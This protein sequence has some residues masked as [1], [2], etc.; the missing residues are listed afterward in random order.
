MKNIGLKVI[1]ALL[2][3]TMQAQTSNC[4]NLSEQLQIFHSNLDYANA[5]KSWL[6]IKKNCPT[7]SE[8]NYL[9]AKEILQYKLD[10]APQ[11][12]IQK[13]LNEFV[14]FYDLYD[15]SFPD[16]KSNNALK[17]AILIV[18][19]TGANE[20]NLQLLERAI[21]KS[22]TAIFDTY[23]TYLFT[24]SYYDK[25]T[26]KEI[27][28]ETFF[29]KYYWATDIL[30]KNKANI[31]E[32]DFNN[33][34]VVM[35]SLLYNGFT[36]DSFENYV[37][38]KFEANQ[39]NL[40]WLNTVSEILSVYNPR[41]EWLEKTTIKSISI[42]KNAKIY[43]Y[44]AQYYLKTKKQ[45]LALDDYEKALEATTDALQKAEIATTLAKLLMVQN[46][47]KAAQTIQI[48]IDNNPKEGKY[49]II[50]ASLYANSGCNFS[51][52]EKFAVLKLAQETVEK[53]GQTSAYLKN[54]AT[55]TKA[56]FQQQIDGLKKPS[57]KEISLE[58]WI[59]KTIKI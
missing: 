19:K 11:D 34:Q 50:L 56:S 15:K 21:N 26:N 16:N 13:P 25:Y 41:S 55:Q 36:P 43:Q 52:D 57:K 5:Y 48:A 47:E 59:H 2:S 31:N 10:I 9:I 14:V 38:A 3:I 4:S 39:E 44:R 7:F 6:E 32:L 33:G 35:R 54:T 29:E 53:A 37:K 1:I 45:S 28:F 27:S 49:Y 23:A 58:C 12:S 42:E 20:E 17:K 40:V 46:P 24:K 51:N 22:K 8:K 30:Q 18:E